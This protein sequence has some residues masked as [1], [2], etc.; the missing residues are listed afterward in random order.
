MKR[1]SWRDTLTV[2]LVSLKNRSQVQFLDIFQTFF[3]HVGAALIWQ[4]VLCIHL[5]MLSDLQAQ[6][7]TTTATANTFG[8]LS[9][10]SDGL[11]VPATSTQV[12]SGHQPSAV[13]KTL[14]PMATEALFP[15]AGREMRRAGSV[16]V[17]I[18]LAF[19]AP[20]SLKI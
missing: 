9:M 17:G 15:C 1:Y 8:H 4:P 2:S 3:A 16:A 7:T 12:L 6:A 5:S 20:G 10:V 13:T 19:G 11:E 14:A 18:L